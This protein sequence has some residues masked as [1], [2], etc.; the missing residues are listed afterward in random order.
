[1]VRQDIVQV[2][3]VVL[4]FTVLLSLYLART[5]AA[6]INKLAATA[7][8]MRRGKPRSVV[9]PTFIDRRDEIGD[10]SAALHDLTNDLWDRMD[11][12]ERFAADVAHEIK[13]PLSS[14]RSAVETAAKVKDPEKQRKL[15]AVI[16]QDVKRLDRLITDIS[17]ASRID[18]EMSRVNVEPVDLR[19]L[20]ATFV[21][22][23]ETT[24][25]GAGGARLEL[26]LAPR[27]ALTVRGHDDR[28]VQVFGN[29]VSNA[30]S[31]S[32]PDGVITISA[33]PA[34]DHVLVIIE[35]QGPGIP[36]SKLADIFQRFYTERPSGEA[37]GQHSGLGLSISK[38]IIEALGGTITAENVYGAD[39]KVR[40][41]RFLIALNRA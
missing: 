25:E 27:G 40:G 34:K 36:E 29:L 5:I 13:N 24:R 15:M 2:F 14:L 18:A 4:F 9:I 10:L 17:R 41:A 1:S 35:D 22:I 3:A 20:L 30:E 19:K 31:F 38:Q 23:H 8:A 39:G 33:T 32:P 7:D 37:F 6:P 12:I 11:A 28:L 26:K 16:E 21:D